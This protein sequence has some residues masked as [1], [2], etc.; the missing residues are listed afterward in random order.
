M[1]FL[2]EHVVQ[3]DF[4]RGKLI[5]LKAAPEPEG[6]EYK[7]IYDRNGR[8]AID[9]AV[10]RDEP[11]LFLI[12]TGFVAVGGSLSLGK[13]QFDELI[14]QG[15]LE[16]SERRGE[17]LHV[18]GD[19]TFRDGWLDELRLGR[20]THKHVIVKDGR[21]NTIGMRHLS[22]YLATFDFPNARLYLR[23]TTRAAEPDRVDL[24]GLSIWRV[25]GEIEV[26]M[27]HPGTPGDAAGVMPGDRIQ[28]VNGKPAST[29]SMF[30]LRSLLGSDGTKIR[31]GI[32][33]PSGKRQIALELSSQT[34]K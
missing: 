17:V 30:Q 1:S 5:L 31:L 25:E 13:R 3:M 20:V 18:D 34:S 33:T 29:F 19:E 9:M 23:P 32:E 24:S 8:P 16:L 15:R 10:G 2:K 26:E 7:L 11:T 27:I 28:M 22:R 14:D 12:D 6:E 21:D 4:E